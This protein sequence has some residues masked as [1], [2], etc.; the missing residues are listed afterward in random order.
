MKERWYEKSEEERDSGDITGMVDDFDAVYVEEQETSLRGAG[1][2]RARK[3]TCAE[4]LAS[5]RERGTIRA[6][7]EHKGAVVSDSADVQSDETIEDMVGNIL[8]GP[9]NRRTQ[10]ASF[11]LLFMLHEQMVRAAAS[12]VV[13]SQDVDDVSQLAFTQAWTSLRAGRYRP[14]NF[15]G[16]LRTITTNLAISQLRKR[17]VGTEVLETDLVEEADEELLD[18]LGYVNLDTPEGRQPRTTQRVW[19]SV[20][21]PTPLRMYVQPSCCGRSGR[22]ITRT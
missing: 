16:W 10:E 9:M 17:H 8:P 5:V 4:L 11:E 12:A 22:G 2:R 13:P 14:G 6:L 7:L 18:T 19:C 1:K 3:V 21:W 15:G 20:G